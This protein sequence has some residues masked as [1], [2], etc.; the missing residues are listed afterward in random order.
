MATTKKK[1]VRNDDPS[2]VPTPAEMTDDMVQRAIAPIVQNQLLVQRRMENM[3][4]QVQ[5]LSEFVS[6]QHAQAVGQ[7]T[8]IPE[9]FDISDEGYHMG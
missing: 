9:A 4:D 2:Y 3:R 8:P 5:R 1:A 7:G 6:I